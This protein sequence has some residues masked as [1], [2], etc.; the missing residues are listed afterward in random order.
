MFNRDQ[1]TCN[2]CKVKG[3]HLHAHHILPY[4]ICNEAFLD[5]ENLVTVCS[6]CHFEKAHKG[7][8]QNFDLDLITDRLKKKYNI[9]GERLNE[10]TLLL[11]KE[12][13]VRPTDIQETVEI[14]RNDQSLSEK[15][16]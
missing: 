13:I 2:Y 14:D 16:E 15:K 5:S 8:W 1:H 6:K 12:A 3:G 9:R 7:N 11:N 10:L 4:W